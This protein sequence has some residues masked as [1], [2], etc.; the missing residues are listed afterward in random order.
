MLPTWCH[1]IERSC[2]VASREGPV[3]AGQVGEYSKVLSKDD[4]RG[5]VSP[6]RSTCRNSEATGAE[7]V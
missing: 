1:L 3:Q 4:S 5:I 7:R 2:V 6:S